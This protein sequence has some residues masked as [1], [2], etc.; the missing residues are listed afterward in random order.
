VVTAL[1]SIVARETAPS[2]TLVVG[3]NAIEGGSAANIVPEEVVLRGNARWFSDR[4]RQ[5]VLRRIPD[6]ARAM[7]EALRAKA[8]FTV[9][10]S[11]PVVVNS[12]EQLK[13]VEEAVAAADHTVIVNPGPLTASDDFARFLEIAPGA[14]IGIGAG[15]PEAAPH[16]HP[17]FDID[18][19]AIALM[20]EILVRTALRT[21]S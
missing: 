5:R 17:R 7:C 13:L 21:L 2:T 16:H 3:I 11:T 14:F 12:R 15:G 8:F 1:Q 10:A 20:T 9:E 18:E 19:R 4:E 6:V